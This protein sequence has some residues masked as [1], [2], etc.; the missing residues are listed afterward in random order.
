MRVA[1]L[2]GPMGAGK[3]LVL[4]QLRL[5]GA[6]CLRADDASRELL[7]SD[8]RLL[9][10]VRDTLGDS[11]FTP[12][13]ALDRRRTAQLVFAD[14][15]ARAALEAIVHP[16]MVAWLRERLGALRGE[17]HP[18]AVAVVEAAIL[19]HMGARGLVDVVVRVWAPPETCAARI[20]Q[21]DG[22]SL[23]QARKRVALHVALGLFDEPADRVLDTS[24]SLEVT[25]S[26][27]SEMWDWLTQSG[28]GPA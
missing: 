28:P 7:G 19:T 12:D 26:R 10:L 17:P 13:G 18:P 8:Q 21:R 25:G 9:A 11:A 1:G 4:E 6:A 22:V 27:V 2:T 15:A 14:P 5:R 16:P 3:S 20:A 24:G 23:E